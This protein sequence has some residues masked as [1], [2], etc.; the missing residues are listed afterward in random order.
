M[1]DHTGNFFFFLHGK[2]AE[3]KLNKLSTLQNRIVEDTDSLYEGSHNPRGLL[4]M[5]NA[6]VETA[7]PFCFTNSTP[8][9][10]HFLEGLCQSSLYPK[11][12]MML[13]RL[14]WGRDICAGRL[15]K[16]NLCEAWG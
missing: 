15:A 7:F 11:L 14:A 16:V 2:P 9:D 8:S 3:M 13:C 6:V 10:F 4:W 12:T 1:A 5:Q